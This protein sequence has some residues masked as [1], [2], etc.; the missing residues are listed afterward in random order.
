MLWKFKVETLFKVENFWGLINGKE[1]NP[2][3]LDAL[4]FLTYEKKER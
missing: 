2:Y 3:Q 4:G 1:V